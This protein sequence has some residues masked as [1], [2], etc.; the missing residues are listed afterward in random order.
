MHLTPKIQS[1]D[2]NPSG[3]TEREFR[4]MGEIFKLSIH[5]LFNKKDCLVLYSRPLNKETQQ[6]EKTSI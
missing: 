2:T 6:P 4:N 3:P 1:M 5:Y